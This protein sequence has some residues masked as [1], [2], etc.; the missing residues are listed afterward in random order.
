MT[1]TV[2]LDR[3]GIAGLLPHGPGMV[4]LD[5]A[6]LVEPGV[7]LHAYHAI[8]GGEPCYAS[9]AA[10][11]PPAYPECLLLESFGQA[12][13]VLWLHTGPVRRADRLLM[14]AAAR[15]CTFSG[16]AYPGDVLR[17]VVRLDHRSDGAAFVS[18][19]TWVGDRPIADYGSLTAVTRPRTAPRK[20]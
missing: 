15:D 11:E 20:E 8:T 2:A 4:L 3:A 7:E 13:G 18:G 9:G 10:A 5:R 19:R 6:V 14:L 12:A 1:A 17:H 16:W